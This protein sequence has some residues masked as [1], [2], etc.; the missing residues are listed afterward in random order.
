MT[1]EKVFFRQVAGQFATGVTVV[2]TCNQGKLTG[3]TV[4]AFC[5]VS[6]DP[7]LILICVDLNSNTLPD[8]RE[9]GIFAVNMLSNEQEHLSSCFATSTEERYEYFCHASFHTAATGS[10]IIDD[11]L[12]FFDA[13]I[14]AEYP[15]GDHVIFDGQVEAMGSNGQ[16]AFANE[17][18]RQ[19]ATIIE[20][21]RNASEEKKLPLAYHLGQYRHLSCDYLKPSLAK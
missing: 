12:A 16:V 14:V 19:Y 20:Y 2:T 1:I 17:E 9:S 5:S 3:L 4:N 15:G 21:E 8:I 11:T 13:R 10:P 6:L 7:P 18:D